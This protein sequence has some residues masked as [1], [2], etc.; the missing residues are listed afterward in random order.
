MFV[1]GTG[2]EGRIFLKGTS[3]LSNLDKSWKIS[4]TTPGTTS[5]KIAQVLQLRAWHDHLTENWETILCTPLA[6]TRNQIIYKTACSL[7]KTGFAQKGGI[8]RPRAQSVAPTVHLSYD[9]CKHRTS[10]ISYPC[11]RI[12]PGT[13]ATVSLGLGFLAE[14]W[15]F[16]STFW[17]FG[18][19]PLIGGR[20]VGRIGQLLV[21]GVAFYT[22]QLVGET[23][24]IL[25]RDL[26]FWR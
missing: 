16:T 7:L 5:P 13:R 3:E 26:Q 10:R 1:D 20:P 12:F 18:R 17:P 2:R 15:S 24:F 8:L 6:P 22:V 9:E 23:H 21:T 25:I 4:K 11:M 19:A 14:P